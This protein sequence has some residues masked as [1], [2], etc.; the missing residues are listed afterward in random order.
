MLG[1]GVSSPSVPCLLRAFAAAAP[2]PPNPFLERPKKCGGKRKIKVGETLR[3]RK[4][5]KNLW[6]TVIGMMLVSS[7]KKKLLCKMQCSAEWVKA[8]LN[9]TVQSPE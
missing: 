6:L 7:R 3:R 9:N 8:P 1:A 5:R 4:K 2:P